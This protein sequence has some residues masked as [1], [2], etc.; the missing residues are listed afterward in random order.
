MNRYVSK[1]PEVNPYQPMGTSSDAQQPRVPG[2]LRTV[3]VGFMAGACP[4]VVV[5]LAFRFFFPEPEDVDLPISFDALLGY[6][7][8]HPRECIALPFL[9]GCISVLG[10]VVHR[11][12]WYRNV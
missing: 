4:I 5:L 2:R 8:E 6:I 11:L 3:T 9:G 10:S 1:K 12:I 7:V